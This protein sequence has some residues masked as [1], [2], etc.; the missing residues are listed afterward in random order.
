MT[1]K[2]YLEKSK[3]EGKK[4]VEKIINNIKYFYVFEKDG[5]ISIINEHYQALCQ[6]ASEEHAD[7]YCTRY[8]VPRVAFNVI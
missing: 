5:W 2:E 7:A 8:E 3:E 1:V 4:V 6:A